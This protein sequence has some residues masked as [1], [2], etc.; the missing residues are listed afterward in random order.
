[1]E[2]KNLIRF[3]RYNWENFEIV[4]EAVKQNGLALEFAGPKMRGCFEI[5]LEAV[6]QNGLALEFADYNLKNHP[7]ILENAIK[8]NQVA[9]K[10]IGL[11]MIKFTK[12]LIENIL[13]KE[14]TKNDI[15]KYFQA[16][17]RDD[18]RDLD[19]HEYLLLKLFGNNKI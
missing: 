7:T 15:S 18:M 19:T 5:V 13:N 11:D 9:I 17:T 10:F 1:M 2:Q 16:L 8:Q 14:I 12:I 6:K 3:T 4:L